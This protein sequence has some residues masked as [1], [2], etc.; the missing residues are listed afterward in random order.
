MELHHIF[1]K[2]IFTRMATSA[3]NLVVLPGHLHQ[4]SRSFISPA[5]GSIEEASP[6]Y[7]IVS[8]HAL[9]NNSGNTADGVFKRRLELLLDGINTKDYVVSATDQQRYV[10]QIKKI[11]ASHTDGNSS[12]CLSICL[13]DNSSNALSYNHEII[14]VLKTF[15][16]S[17]KYLRRIPL[18]VTINHSLTDRQ[19]S[20]KFTLTE[21]GELSYL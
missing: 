10:D 6:Y 15:L 4:N 20:H 19:V 21:N 14:E 16:L 3:T 12:L 13:R 8:I 11:T 5:S 9:T 17:K 7:G 2:S 1:P 18:V